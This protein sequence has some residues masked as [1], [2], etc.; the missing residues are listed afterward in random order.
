MKGPIKRLHRCS[1]LG[2]KNRKMKQQ[3]QGHV[4]SGSLLAPFQEPKP[5][6]IEFLTVFLAYRLDALVISLLR[7]P[8][9]HTG[10][11]PLAFLCMDVRVQVLENNSNDWPG[12]A[13]GHRL[14]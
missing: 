1:L 5:S 12:M 9:V 10:E 4:L 6:A 11:V 13:E 14:S 3:N 8:S 2:F 7:E